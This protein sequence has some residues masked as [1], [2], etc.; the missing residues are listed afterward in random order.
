MLGLV[1]IAELNLTLNAG[2]LTGLVDGDRM[3]ALND[4]VP[5][6]DVEQIFRYEWGGM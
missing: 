6:L 5:C 1:E 3:C 2:E 4:G